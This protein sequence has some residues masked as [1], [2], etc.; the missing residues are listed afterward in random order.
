MI[1]IVDFI[2]QYICEFA[3]I[4]DGIWPAFKQFD[5]SLL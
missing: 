3:D 4:T 2:A 5:E 1:V